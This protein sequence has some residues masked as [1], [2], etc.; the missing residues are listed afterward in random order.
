LGA[1]KLTS[2]AG[3]K[4]LPGPS[5]GGP[6]SI[7]HEDGAST[8]VTGTDV[9]SKAS[10]TGENGSRTSPEKLKPVLG[11]WLMKY[12]PK[13][14]LTDLPNIASTT[15]SVPFKAEGKSSTNGISRFLSWVARRYQGK[16]I[17]S[18]ELQY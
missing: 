16:K 4:S 5:F 2:A 8:E 15:W 9:F 1:V 7:F 6:D 10:M 14:R 3:L 17:S 18:L 12:R 11:R 13:T